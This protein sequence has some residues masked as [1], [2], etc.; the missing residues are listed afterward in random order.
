[1]MPDP[2]PPPGTPRWVRTFGIVAL[3]AIV[4]LIILLLAGGHGPGRHASK[5]DVGIASHT[6]GPTA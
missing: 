3:I 5:G 4:L 2:S 1:M 6:D